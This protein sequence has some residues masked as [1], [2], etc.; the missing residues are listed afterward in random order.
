M[1]SQRFEGSFPHGGYGLH[2]DIG[3]N[4]YILFA[5]CDDDG[6]YDQT[7]AALS[8]SDA[9]TN[10]QGYQEKIKEFSLEERIS[11][12]DLS[13]KTG[14][15]LNVTYFPP[16]PVVKINGDPGLTVGFI[17]LTFGG[18]F[19]KTVKIYATGLIDIE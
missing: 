3:N 5:D 12:S 2:F 10:Q 18:E 6:Q 16:D 8:C 13:P 15:S 1:S 11:I 7:G 17:T 9:F 4:S 19:T 14:N